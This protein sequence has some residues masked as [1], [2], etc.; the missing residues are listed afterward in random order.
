[1]L[2][3]HVE[4][5][6]FI[7]TWV[8]T[9]WL[10]SYKLTYTS[11][12]GAYEHIDVSNLWY[13][14]H[15]VYGDPLQ[16]VQQP[17][18]RFDLPPDYDDVKLRLVMTG[19]GQGNSGNAAEFLWPVNVLMINEVKKFGHK[20]WRDDCGSNTCSPQNGNW[21]VSRSGWCPGD[22][23]PSDDLMLTE[24]LN[25]GKSNSIEY[26]LQEYVNE[27]RPDNANCDSSVCTD[28]NYNNIGH[29][30]PYY[31]ISMQLVTYYK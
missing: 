5:V 26:V 17:V 25:S 20:L 3:G 16:S 10:V 21:T 15:L 14:D 27:C 7:D 31:H 19:H 30:E 23:V 2:T 24:F 12:A 1:L 28:C 8:N 11:G 9:G 22:V 29:T 13:N 6:S 18:V 4:F